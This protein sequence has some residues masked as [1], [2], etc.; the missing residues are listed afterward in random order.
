MSER[1]VLVVSNKCPVCEVLVA[2]IQE[3]K[4]P[5]DVVDVETEE[6]KSI[7]AKYDITAVPECMVLIRENS[8]KQGRFCNKEE[9]EELLT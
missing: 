9:L 1:K 3:K 7:V 5:I 4:L 8:G 6:G 2:N